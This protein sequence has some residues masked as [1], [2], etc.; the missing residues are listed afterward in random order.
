ME[1]II[2]VSCKVALTILAAVLSETRDLS[3]ANATDGNLKR[4]VLRGFL[5]VLSSKSELSSAVDVE[6]DSENEAR[7][8][9][10]FVDGSE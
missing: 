10:P 4:L 7:V 1:D 2:P 9:A 3:Q 5:S 6:S 8:A